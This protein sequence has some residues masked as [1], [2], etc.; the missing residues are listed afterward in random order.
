M[1][2]KSQSGFTLV[3]MLV[4]IG[5]STVLFIGIITL[6]TTIYRANSETLRQ[7]QYVASA[8]RGVETFVRDAREIDYAV[9][10]AYPLV[11]MLPY[12]FSFYSDIDPDNS[13]EFIVY[14]LA[15]SSL[16]RTVYSATGTP[17]LYS[18]VPDTVQVL[19][20]NLQ[21]ALLGIPLFTYY[22][23]TA[24]VVSDPNDSIIDVRAV[25]IS[26]HINPDL[27]T[28]TNFILEGNA[29]LRNLRDRL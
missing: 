20:T 13:T 17:P 12:Q 9:T 29:T 5:I 26:L 15:T 14:E 16:Q 3:E 22:D 8:Q 18:T 1:Q 6:I 27:S 4:V 19:A 2:K 23:R 11:T 28:T 7:S 25:G 10:G 21:N 24:G